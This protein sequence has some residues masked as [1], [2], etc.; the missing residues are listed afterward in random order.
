[1]VYLSEIVVHHRGGLDPLGL[2]SHEQ[3]F[4]FIKST[5]YQTVEGRNQTTESYILLM[6]WR[7]MQCG[8]ELCM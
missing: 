7:I 3:N 2:S 8:E 4:I 1:V 6:L 5:E